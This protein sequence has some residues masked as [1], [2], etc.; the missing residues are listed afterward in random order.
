M[1]RARTFVLGTAVATGIALLTGGASAGIATYTD[2]AA[3]TLAS[4]GVTGSED[5]EGFA[6][7]TSFNGA[8]IALDGALVRN[9]RS[10]GDGAPSAAR[11]E[12]SDGRVDVLPARARAEWS[13]GD[14]LVIETAGGGAWGAPAHRQVTPENPTT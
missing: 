14:R 3:W 6:T 11:I 8:V 10:T 2:R 5:F 9:A 4:G 13:A 7:D 12:R 1:M